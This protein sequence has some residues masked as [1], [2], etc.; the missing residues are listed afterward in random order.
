MDLKGK[1]CED[2]MKDLYVV[3][4]VAQIDLTSEEYKSLDTKERIRKAREVIFMQAES[5]EEN[6]LVTYKS[7]FIRTDSRF[8]FIKGS[9]EVQT[10]ENNLITICAEAIDMEL[11]VK[12]PSNVLGDIV[13]NDDDVAVRSAFYWDGD[14][15]VEDSR[16]ADF[17]EILDSTVVE[18]LAPNDRIEKILGRAAMQ[19]KIR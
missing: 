17:I 5:E 2:L 4:E 8:V 13:F 16:A 1:I 3:T 12:S 14:I 11:G 7:P 10:G 19:E 6:R 18:L 15:S 9:V